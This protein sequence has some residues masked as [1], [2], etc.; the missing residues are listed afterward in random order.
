MELQ[1][2][3]VSSDLKAQTNYVDILHTFR[4]TVSDSH[5]SKTN[6]LPNTSVFCLSLLHVSARNSSHHK[7]HTGLNVISGFHRDPCNTEGFWLFQL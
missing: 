2:V 5:T 6:L 4:T 7:G 3:Q 1:H